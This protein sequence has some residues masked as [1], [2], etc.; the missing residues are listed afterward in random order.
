MNNQERSF[1][2]HPEVLG[3]VVRLLLCAA[4]LIGVW[5][6]IPERL[7]RPLRQADAA[8]LSF[9]LRLLGLRGEAH[10]C[11]VTAGG[12]Q[13]A[14][15][16]ECLAVDII[17]LYSAFVFAYPSRT[18]DRFRGI[19]LGLPFLYAANLLRVVMLY[20]AGR[21]GKT[22]FD[23]SHIYLGQSFAIL[24]V[25]A[26]VGWWLHLTTPTSIVPRRCRF[27]M[28]V[29]VVSV[30]GFLV[31]I[32]LQWPYILAMEWLMNGAFSLGGMELVF[33]RHAVYEYSFNIVPFVALI[34]ASE[35][36]DTR[37]KLRSLLFGLVIMGLS[38][39]AFK[40]AQ[41]LIGYVS[42]KH[43]DAVLIGVYRVSAVVLPVALWLWV[44][45]PYRRSYRCPVCGEKRVGLEDHIRAKHGPQALEDESV[46]RALAHVAAIR[47]CG[48]VAERQL[49]PN[50]CS[51]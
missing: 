23:Y 36:I 38:H 3:F 51:A 25:I 17:L 44:K 7:F 31:W 49:P 29:F 12:F 5:S 32:P 43:A 45:Y 1:R 20:F 37:G 19:A 35:T 8:V 33:P 41:V 13:V 27:L 2:P 18:V 22:L 47:A 10:G 50:R 46:K 26:A 15:A 14:I 16:K 42:L 6:F 9:V 39:V 30:A 11:T 21:T 24:A 40:S 28:T 48:F 4:A 34:I